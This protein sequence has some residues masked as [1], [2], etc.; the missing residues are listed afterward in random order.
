MNL[1]TFS[2]LIFI[3][4]ISFGCSPKPKTTPVTQDSFD[5]EIDPNTMTLVT[6]RLTGK[7]LP[8]TPKVV[9]ANETATALFERFGMSCNVK[10]IDDKTWAG[11]LML[12]YSYVIGWITEEKK[13]F[14]YCSEPF[15]ATKDLEV[16]F[17]PGMPSTFEYTLPEP[18][19]NIPTFPANL[20][21]M[22]K[23][24]SNGQE[25]FLSW[26]VNETINEPGSVK[27]EGLAAGT[28][29]LS[30]TK[31]NYQQYRKDQNP[32]LLDERLIEI[33]ND[34]DNHVN[35]VFPEIDTTVEP[36]D[37]IIRGTLYDNNIKPL[38]DMIV[39][40][41]PYIFET[42]EQ[43]LDLYYHRIITDPNG[44]FEFVG[45][46][47]N[48]TYMVNCD[49]SSI[50]LLKELM[51]ENASISLDL[52]LGSLTLPTEVGAPAPELIIDWKDGDSGKLSD[53]IGKTAVVNCWASWCQACEKRVPEL[54]LLASQ[55]SERDDIVFIELC[56]DFD[57]SVWEQTLDKHNW[58]HLHHGWL[59][60]KKNSYV[61]NKPLPYSIIIDKNGIL[62][63]VNMNLDIKTE[64]KKIH[65]DLN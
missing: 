57:R 31:S 53:F 7:T 64:L 38:P 39:G 52:V 27:I 58:D 14:G 47:P 37:I 48:T 6:Y 35:A 60:L 61:I 20:L 9:P 19:E 33:K 46:R 12:G 32:F 8:G 49:Y 43:M 30:V 63:A 45:V 51:K 44:K 15:T 26:G 17:S 55:L 23:T 56:I 18:P 36:N 62:R 54:N 34:S 29:K 25:T 3:L 13:L 41:T 10:Q 24:I 22:I 5:F 28:Y 4:I 42:K 59:D 40:L 16:T 21:L 1:R 11:P 2:Y 65:E 50:L